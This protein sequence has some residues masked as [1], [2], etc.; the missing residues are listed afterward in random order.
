[1]SD[2][3]VDV[4]SAGVYSGMSLEDFGVRVST[5]LG[6]EEVAPRRE[7][8]ASIDHL[9]EELADGDPLSKEDRALL[10]DVLSQASGVLEQEDE[11]GHSLSDAFFDDLGEAARRFE[12][13]H[14][15]LAPVL[16]RIASALSQLGI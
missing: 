8:K 16:G 13:S 12:E 9:R 2:G 3:F 14:P 7:L 10:D 5:P 6:G 11:S 15:K 4:D 1:M